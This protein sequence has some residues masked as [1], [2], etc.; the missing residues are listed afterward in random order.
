M[1]IS[2]F[3]VVSMFSVAVFVVFL[4]IEVICQSWIF[5][6]YNKV[7]KV[8][9]VTVSEGEEWLIEKHGSNLQDFHES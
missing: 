6:K 4:V 5:G 2:S 9:I 3:M 7:K 8:S 1:K